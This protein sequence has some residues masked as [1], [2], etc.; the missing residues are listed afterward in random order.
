M[1]KSNGVPAG[2]TPRS[3]NTAPTRNIVDTAIAA[4]DLSIFAAAIE[5]AGLTETLAA[6]GPFTVF[7]P[8]DEAF[9]NLPRGSYDGLLKDSAK[10]RAVLNY[11]VVPGYFNAKDLRSGEIMTQQGTT[12]TVDAADA[13]TRVNAAHIT[14]ADLPATNGVVHALDTVILPKKWHLLAAAA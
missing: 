14:R 9:R 13:Q 5:T 4:G 3:T 7:A 6:K 1:D 10:L 11:H 2:N 12:L 8:T